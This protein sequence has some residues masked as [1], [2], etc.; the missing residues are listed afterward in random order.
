[1]TDKR[2]LSPAAKAAL[3][4]SAP[5]P[6]AQGHKDT[7]P[8][9][10]TLRDDDNELRAV[11]HIVCMLEAFAPQQRERMLAY[12]CARLNITSAGQS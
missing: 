6:L 5:M 1:M 10:I 8:L 9:T 12:I 7:E 11:S 3:D 2:E 4:R